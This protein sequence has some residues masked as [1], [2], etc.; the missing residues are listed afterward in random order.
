M[1]LLEEPLEEVHLKDIVNDLEEVA[2]DWMKIG[3]QLGLKPDKLEKIDS[4]RK[5]CSDKLREMLVQWL[6]VEKHPTRMAIVKALESS[7]VGATRHAAKLREKYTSNKVSMKGGGREPVPSQPQSIL[8]TF[9]DNK[10]ENLWVYS[11]HKH[12]HGCHSWLDIEHLNPN[13]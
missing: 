10:R 1:D 9:T 4:E 7:S 13:Y 6:R 11:G 3:L 2:K 8:R 5:E 12:C